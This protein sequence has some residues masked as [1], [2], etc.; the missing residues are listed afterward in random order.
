MKRGYGCLLTN[1][2]TMLVVLATCAVSAYVVVVYANPATDINPFQPATLPPLAVLPSPSATAT[3]SLFP[4]FPATFTPS[5]TATR[6][7]PASATSVPTTTATATPTLPPMT[8]TPAATATQDLTRIAQLTAS[9]PTNTPQPT[10]TS[11]PTFTPTKTLSAF[12]FT[13]QGGGPTPIQNF[14]NSAGCNWMGIAGQ[15]FS[16]DG[17]PIVGYVVHLAG[18]GINQDA[19]TGTKTAY[20][21][22]GY[23]FPLNNRPVQSSGQFKLQLFNEKGNV[24]LSD[25]VVVNTFADCTKNLLLVNFIQ[26]H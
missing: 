21:A 8:A 9:V 6:T 25:V 22:G 17:N 5:P 14:A 4:T 26:N 18:G 20:G 2:L 19:I 16:L 13:V 23:E 11:A 10:N 7:R 15:A 24:P 3:I 12:P 1:I